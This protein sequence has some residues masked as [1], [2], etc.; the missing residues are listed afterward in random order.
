MLVLLRAVD[1]LTKQEVLAAQNM[2]AL[3]TGDQVE[4]WQKEFK[5]L[6]LQEDDLRQKIQIVAA[7]IQSY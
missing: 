3:P 4:F 7:K 6:L 2:A 5:P 1:S